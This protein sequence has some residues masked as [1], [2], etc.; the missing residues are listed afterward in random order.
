MANRISAIGYI[1]K[2]ILLSIVIV[3]G[4]AF[5]NTC[6]A[7]SIVGKWKGV[8]I[9]YYYS[10]DYAKQLGKSM[11][12]K[13]VKELGNSEIDY[14]ADHTFVMTMS[15]P[16]STDITTMKG[17][18][19]ATGD[20]LK[21]TLEPQFNPQKIT[22]TASYAIHGNTLETTAIMAPP[23]RIIKSVSIGTRL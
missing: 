2:S 5:W 13:T 16:N 10:A 8:S 4:V 7:Q 23:S 14:N 17:T 6:D 18:W 22:S 20:Q 15:A 1:S 19:A 11:E 3:S 9:K 21:L 12:E